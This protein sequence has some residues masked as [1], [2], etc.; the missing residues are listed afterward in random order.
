MLLS[1]NIA[2][3]QA[4]PTYSVTAQIAGSGGSWDYATID[5][6][7]GR[8][9][10]AQRGVTALDLKTG[11]LN[12]GLLAAGVTHGVA[13]L[14][15]GKVAVADSKSESVK[16]FEGVSGKIL[17]DISTAQYDPIGGSHTLD[18]LVVEPKTGLMVAVNGEPGSCS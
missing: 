9:Y 8:L 2:V 18:A 5:E 14:G 10:L 7:A 3:A 17:A 1:T 6:D 12:T 4:R 16:I 13:V 15:D 11:R